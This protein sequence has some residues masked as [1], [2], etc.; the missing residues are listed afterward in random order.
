MSQRVVEQYLYLL[1]EAFSGVGIEASDESQSLLANLRAVGVDDWR[2]VPTG[3]K[4]AI[5]DIAVHVGACKVMY[6]DH[7]FGRASLDWTDP[8]VNPWPDAAPGKAE[9]LTWLSEAQ[10]QLRA[11]VAALHDDEFMQPRR[12]NWGEWKET[13]WLIKT[14]IEHDLYHAGEINHIHACFKATTCGGMRK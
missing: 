12:A 11:H 4:R 5:R 9:V 1:D 13:R 3:G 8:Q 2:R 14:I 6:G 10:G 7:A